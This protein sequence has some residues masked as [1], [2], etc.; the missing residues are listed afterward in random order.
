MVQWL[1]LPCFSW[2]RVGSGSIPG[3]GTKLLKA[4]M[5]PPPPKKKKQ[6]TTEEVMHRKNTSTQGERRGGP[7][8]T[9]AETRRMP[10]NI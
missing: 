3:S 8:K 7:V 1:G 6:N 9:E 2:P 5:Q 10:R 4:A